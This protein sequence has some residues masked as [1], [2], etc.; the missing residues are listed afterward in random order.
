M[1]RPQKIPHCNENVRG[2][3]R[4]DLGGTMAGTSFEAAF[5][6]TGRVVLVTGG[7]SGIGRAIAEVFAAR[8][9]HLVLA[10]RSDSVGHTASALP[11]ARHVAVVADVSQPGEAERVVSEALAAHDRLDVLVNN[12][13]IV[14]LAPAEEVTDDEWDATMAVNLKAPFL[15]ARA[16]FQPLCHSGAGRIINLASQ[17]AGVALDRH[18]AYCTSKAGILGLTRVLAA[19]WA[20]HGITVNAISPTVVETELGRRAWAGEVGAVMKR[21][22][23]TGRFAQPEEIAMAALYLASGAAGM[24]TGENL[25]IDGGYT[26]Q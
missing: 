3:L 22:I 12:A 4:L 14:L 18:L 26:I 8:G 2:G 10:D 20:K 1:V 21:K 6:M 11:G 5:D 13:G 19:E 16:A 15:M 23:P 9:A 25:I 24:I 17:A 7:A